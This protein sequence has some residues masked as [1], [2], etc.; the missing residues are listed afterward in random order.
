M[1]TVYT[2]NGKVLKNAANDK[3][4]KK[5]EA[6]PLP[7]IPAY[8]IRAK[9]RTGTEPS[10]SGPPLTF[11]L[12][13]ATQNI[14]DITSQQYFNYLG[15][16][17]ADAAEILDWNPGEASSVNTASVIKGPSAKNYLTKISLS[18]FG[19]I[20]EI[21]ELFGGSNMSA[22][23]EVHLSGLNNVT[24]M[25][26]LCVSCSALETLSLTGTHNVTNINT[27]CAACTSLKAVPDFDVSSVSSCQGAFD[28]CPNVESGALNMYNKLSALGSQITSST[29]RTFVNCGAN[30]VTGA[31]ELAQIPSSWG[32]TGA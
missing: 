4:L 30:T 24:N 8:T 16:G 22:L 20:T 26:N 23:K 9:I 25:Y 14:W 6:A 11:T 18:N 28:S 7:P 5:A 13:D 15:Y 27:L 12:V 3:W 10:S 21:P 29:D 19:N 31:A 2:L 32:G 1:S 17:L